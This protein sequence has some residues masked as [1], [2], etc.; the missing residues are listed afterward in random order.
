MLY[1]KVNL[2][3][4]NNTGRWFSKYCLVPGEILKIHRHA[5]WEIPDG[6]DYED[7]AVLDPICNAYK[8]IAQQS[9]FLPGQDVVVIG[10]GPRAVLRTNGA[11]YGGGKYRRRWSARRCGG[12]LPGCKEL[13]ATAVVN[14]STEDVVARCQQICGK[15]N[16]GLVIECSG[17]NIALKQAIEMLRPNGKWYA[18][19]W[20]SNLL[21]SRLMTLPP[22]TKA[23]LGIWPMTPPHGVTLS[24][25]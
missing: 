14:G 11:N 10:T 23:S 9:K 17:A 25:Y 24:G 20:A 2:G 19:E 12:P 6:V 1:R 8:S 5:L 7:A 21:I 3:L 16:L 4:D 15:D 13:G 18:L 22:G